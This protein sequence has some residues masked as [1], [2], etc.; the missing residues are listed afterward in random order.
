[1]VEIHGVT[2]FVAMDSPQKLE[3]EWAQAKAATAEKLSKKQHVADYDR[4]LPTYMYKE[5][6][7]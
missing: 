3:K 6:L 1:M 2:I 7:R 5:C 4:E